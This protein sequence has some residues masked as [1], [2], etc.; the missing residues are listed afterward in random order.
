MSC[1]PKFF[2]CND[3]KN[4]VQL[5]AGDNPEHLKCFSETM[6]ELTANTSEGASE[7]HLPVVERNYNE[8]TVKVGS[9][10]HPMSEEHSINWVYLQT[11]KG[12]QIVYLSPQD[13]P[14]AQ[15]C[16]ANGDEPLAAYA[17]CN[18]HGFWKTEI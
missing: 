1:E 10:F 7:K 13:E 6:T 14:V 4:I 8:V 11:Q 15:F 12:G 2:S 9:V 17:W 16:V 18:L 3:G 5:I